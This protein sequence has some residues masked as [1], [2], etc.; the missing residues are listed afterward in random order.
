MKTNRYLF[1]FIFSTPVIILQGLIVCKLNYM[2][3]YGINTFVIFFKLYIY[4]FSSY[5]LKASITEILGNEK[6]MEDLSM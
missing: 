4:H 1:F 6:L 5:L 3:N 2:F